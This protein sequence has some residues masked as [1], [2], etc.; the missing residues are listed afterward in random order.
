MKCGAYVPLCGGR[1]GSGRGSARTPP[2]GKEIRSGDGANAAAI[3]LGLGD[4]GLSNVLDTEVPGRDGRRRG[5]EGKNEEEC[6]EE[7]MR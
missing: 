4:R 3:F 5:G 1:C 6:E 7:G 2:P